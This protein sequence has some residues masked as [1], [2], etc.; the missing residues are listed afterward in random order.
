VVCPEYLRKKFAQ[1]RRAGRSDLMVA[2]SERLNL[3]RTGVKR[4]DLPARV[5]WFKDRVLPQAVLAVLEGSG[6]NH[7]DTA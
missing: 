6:A 1:V 4:E 7:V 3:E 5:V 2:I